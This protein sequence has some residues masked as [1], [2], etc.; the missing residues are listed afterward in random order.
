[1]KKG[2]NIIWVALISL[3]IITAQANIKQTKPQQTFIQKEETQMTKV[4]I[5]WNM[6][7]G[8]IRLTETGGHP[9]PT[10]AVGDNGK[11]IGPYQ[12]SKAYWIDSQVAGKWEDCKQYEYSRLVMMRYWQ[13][14]CLAASN[15]KDWKTMARIHNGGPHGNTK[16][17]TLKYWEKVQTY[18]KN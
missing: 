4:K 13:R 10:E 7:F 2:H 1:M 18:L 15:K 8:A 3:L 14:Y 5:D 17:S 12:I 9:K 11:S 6:F 16:A